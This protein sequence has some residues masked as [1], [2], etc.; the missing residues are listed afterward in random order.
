[1]DVLESFSKAMDARGIGHG[2]YYSLVQ[3]V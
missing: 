1:V 3:T 2:F